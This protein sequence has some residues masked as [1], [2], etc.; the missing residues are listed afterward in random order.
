MNQLQ[1]LKKLND[2]YANLS[3]LIGAVCI[4]GMVPMSLYF[5]SAE[6]AAGWMMI[7]TAVFVAIMVGLTVILL[8]VT[9]NRVAVGRWRIFQ[10]IMAVL[11]LTSN[12][13]LGTAYGAYAL[14]VCWG[15]PESRARFDDPQADV[16]AADPEAEAGG[17]KFHRIARIVMV[18]FGIF[19]ALLAGGTFV[20]VGYM[21]QWGG[22]EPEV[23]VSQE[24]IEITG[25]YGEVIDRAGLSDVELKDDLPT[26]TLRSN[27][28]ALGGTLK[29]WFKTTEYDSVKLFVHTDV[30]P[31]LYLHGE[32]HLVIY[33]ADDPAETRALYQQLRPE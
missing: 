19:Y 9:G 7:G 32:D 12:P 1:N 15:H 29:G 16:P 17:N 2:T 14:W 3:L 10:T 26:I 13:P 20:G 11:N 33:G 6:P 27:G 18:V 24:S 21:M 30:E 23:I 28:Y 22:Q 25:M 31:F 4:L 5:L 8:K